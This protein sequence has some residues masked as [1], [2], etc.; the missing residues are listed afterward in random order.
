MKQKTESMFDLSV[1]CYA[2]STVGGGEKVDRAEMRFPTSRS[3]TTVVSRL[4]KV[5]RTSNLREFNLSYS[6]GSSRN[7]H[8]LSNQI[9]CKKRVPNVE[10]T[11]ETKIAWNEK[12]QQ[13]QAQNGHRNV[14][15]LDN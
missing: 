14:E 15:K 11:L 7:D 2:I 4:E 5:G 9:L 1:I 12:E 6:R 3:A 13:T 8:N 10:D